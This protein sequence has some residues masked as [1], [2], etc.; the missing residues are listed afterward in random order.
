MAVRNADD[1]YGYCDLDTWSHANNL[2]RPMTRPDSRYLP[3]VSAHTM[4]S[5]GSQPPTYSEVAASES[6]AIL[7]STPPTKEEATTAEDIAGCAVVV[8]LVAMVTAAIFLAFSWTDDFTYFVE[9][10]CKYEVEKLK[11]SSIESCTARNG[12]KWIK[13]IVNGMLFGFL[14]FPA[15]LLCFGACLEP[16]MKRSILKQAREIEMESLPQGP[17]PSVVENV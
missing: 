14:A 3:S 1:M 15:I 7:T 9:T 5:T 16:Q 2:G 10:T 17:R 13:P 6:T 11:S 8:V 12:D 4:P